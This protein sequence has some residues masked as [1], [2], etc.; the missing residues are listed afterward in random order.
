[1]VA[2]FTGEVPV[3]PAEASRDSGGPDPGETGGALPGAPPAGLSVRL[4]R[5]Q[6][7]AAVTVQRWWRHC[8]IRLRG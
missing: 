4:Q 2:V 8:L 5:R 1:M 3:V 6:Q 7:R